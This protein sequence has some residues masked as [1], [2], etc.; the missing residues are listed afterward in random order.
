MPGSGLDGALCQFPE[1]ANKTAMSHIV[2][3]GDSIFDNAAYVPGQPAVIDQVR[4]Q[5]ADG[6]VATLLAVDGD[7]TPDVAHQLL[8]LPDDATHLFVSVGGNDALGHSHI[9]NTSGTSVL[10]EL[11][12]AYEGFRTAYR[13]MLDEVCRHRKPTTLCTIYDSVP[14]LDKVAVMALSVFNDTILREAFS[15]GLPVIDL[16]FVC[17]HAEDYSMLSVIEP[18]SIGGA[19]IAK[20]IGHVLRNHDFTLNRTIVYV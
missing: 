9:L 12:Q 6:D 5:M 17:S 8:D 10:S 14:G 20:T 2:L 15:R 18:S 3:L 16:R 7:V 19:K 13:S 11:T 4:E 1:A